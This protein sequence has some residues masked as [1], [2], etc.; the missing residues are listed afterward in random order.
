MC[1][2]RIVDV[3]SAEKTIA[4]SNLRAQRVRGA[5]AALYLPGGNPF[6]VRGLSA[7]SD[8]V[9]FHS[10]PPPPHW[11]SFESKGKL[12]F[13]VAFGLYRQCIQVG[14]RHLLKRVRI[15][16]LELST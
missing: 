3:T 7:I 8:M 6:A 9:F 12:L 11:V 15:C 5:I 1:Y 10:E 16:L 2:H 14:H 4:I 13:R